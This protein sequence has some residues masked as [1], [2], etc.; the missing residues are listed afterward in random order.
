[1][2]LLKLYLRLYICSYFLSAFCSV[3]LLS[4]VLL[5]ATPWTAAHQASLSIT[6]SW[7]LLKLMSIES[8]IPSNRL[9]SSC[10]QSFPASGSLQMS[11]FFASGGRSIGASALASVL[12]MSIQD[13]LLLGWAGFIPLQSKRLSSFL[14]PQ[15][16]KATVLWCSAFFVVRFF[17][18]FCITETLFHFLMPFIVS[19]FEKSAVS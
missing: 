8:V 5:F 9:I 11:Q 12:P 7:S 14:K 1:M 19:V 10:F 13:G 3:Q 2:K 17:I 18:P 15:S 6:N 4:C 16:S